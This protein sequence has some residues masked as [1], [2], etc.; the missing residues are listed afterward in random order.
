MARLKIPT[1]FHQGLALIMRLSDDAVDALISALRDSPPAIDEH[2]LA[3][4]V[5]QKIDNVA[6]DELEVMLE[7]LINLN[8]T[9]R[10]SIEH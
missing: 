10:L 8:A 9:R 1:A 3:Q 7:T 2:A 4:T 6:L 5:R